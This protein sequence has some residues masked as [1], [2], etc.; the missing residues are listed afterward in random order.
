M[1]K[2]SI[3][4]I[5]LILLSGCGHIAR[6]EV[7]IGS[8]LVPTEDGFVLTSQ[9]GGTWDEKGESLRLSVMQSKVSAAGL[10]RGGYDIVKRDVIIND[11]QPVFFGPVGTI[12]YHA[13][14]RSQNP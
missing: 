8:N 14:C 9:V 3:S 13:K 5:A 7:S 12:F 4:F 2:I 6:K 10:C 11:E 1:L